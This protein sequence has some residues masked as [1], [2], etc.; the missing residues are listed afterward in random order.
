[1]TGPYQGV[2]GIKRERDLEKTQKSIT[3]TMVSHDLNLAAI[4]LA[5]DTTLPTEC[6]PVRC[7]IV[8]QLS[9]DPALFHARLFDSRT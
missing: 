6:G 3:V 9:S 8:D 2:L 4:F 5:E 1:M 7:L